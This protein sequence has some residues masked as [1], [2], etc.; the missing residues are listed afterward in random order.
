M[1]RAA[2]SFFVGV[3]AGFRSSQH[4]IYEDGAYTDNLN[5]VLSSGAFIAIYSALRFPGEARQVGLA[6]S[7]E[8]AV[9]FFAACLI[10]SAVPKNDYSHK[11]P[12]F[13][14]MPKREL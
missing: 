12:L 1:S 9:G 2:I 4:Y 14:G 13:A 3:C 6:T 11:P 7:T 10:E 8:F 5:V